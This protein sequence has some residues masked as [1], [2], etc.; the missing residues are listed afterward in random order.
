MKDLFVSTFT[1]PIRIA[2]L[3]GEQSLDIEAFVDT[4]ASMTTLP[5]T[6]LRELG[7]EAVARQQFT[8]ANGQ[9]IERDIGYAIATIGDQSLMTYV[10]FGDEDSPLLLGALT[11]EAFALAVDPR[12]ETLVPRELIMY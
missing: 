6:L 5:A 3:N 2:S 10:A 12:G 9:R 8:I 1:W 4:G 7:V 11:L